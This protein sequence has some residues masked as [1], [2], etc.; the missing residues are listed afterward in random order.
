MGWKAWVRFL[1]AE[2]DLYLHSVQ[3]GSW[4]RPGSH[5]KVT[6]VSL[7]GSETDHSFPSSDDVKN[8]GAITSLPI[9]LHDAVLN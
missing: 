4:D 9:R 7:P 1:T 2:R 6:E 5:I 3:T 8:G